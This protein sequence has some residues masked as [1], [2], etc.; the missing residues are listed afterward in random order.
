MSSSDFK[1]ILNFSKNFHA[2]DPKAL[3]IA[4]SGKEKFTELSLPLLQMGIRPQVRWAFD[5]FPFQS[6]VEDTKTYLGNNL[7]K[8]Q[9][10]AQGFVSMPHDAQIFALQQLGLTLADVAAGKVLVI[11]EDSGA[12]LHAKD[13]AAEEEFAQLSDYLKSLLNPGKFPD[14]ETGPVIA[15][16]GGAENFFYS[17]GEIAKRRP[18]DRGLTQISLVM[19][20]SLN[21][22]DE[23][24][25]VGKKL[26]GS[27]ISEP[28]PRHG[29]LT[30]DNFMIPA[31]IDGT[32]ENHLTIAELGEA[33]MARH[34]VKALALQALVKKAGLATGL[35]APVVIAQRKADLRVGVV[36]NGDPAEKLR[37]IRAPRGVEIVPLSA[38]IETLAAV[39]TDIFA[40]AD[41][42]VLAFT[43]D[44]AAARENYWRNLYILTSLCT[45]LLT[46]DRML[47]GKGAVLANFDNRHAHLTDFAD[48]IHALGN[49]AQERATLFDVTE[50]IEQGLA[51]LAEKQGPV[52]P[53]Q[54]PAFVPHT[55]PGSIPPHSDEGVAVLLSGLN[56]HG[57]LMRQA[58]KFALHQ[59]RDEGRPIITGAG[60]R[61][62]MGG[63]TEILAP[64]LSP[65]RQIW[66]GGA[67]TPTIM[68]IEGN[69]A[70]QLSH[71]QLFASIY[72]RMRY[73]FQ[74]GLAAWLYGG[75]G[76]YQ[77]GS[78]WN[79]LQ[80]LNRRGVR[81]A[82]TEL[83][84]GKPMAIYN[85][86]IT[87][88]GVVRGVYDPVL[89]SMPEEDREILNI[90]V[91]NSCPDMN[92]LVNA[93][94]EERR[95]LGL[96]RRV[97]PSHLRLA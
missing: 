55:R 57:G 37:G 21:R 45:G 43:G 92:Q 27:W 4:T 50:S 95:T 39:E 31:T 68:G 34:S 2:D 86:Q 41:S 70:D 87:Q 35:S 72:P 3:L 11:T 44:K 6:P 8:M 65:E 46:H 54:V 36:V 17:L 48:D 40:R 93:A 24:V 61:G 81:N 52:I 56:E 25:C 97:Q 78:G 47:E 91:A 7:K 18:L 67:T 80:H 84:A 16:M 88:A 74:A 23:I 5:L 64:L 59:A 90:G 66:H 60:K 13:I 38:E 32:A 96:G 51:L 63:I 94:F 20:A 82:D 42:F 33:Y 26:E 22:P 19:L 28:R 77:E 83:V 14:V 49:A 53:K 79:M 10:A 76:T 75:W 69:V 85:H 73:I 9:A 15:A 62:G 29:P 71:F 12:R 89:M 58:Q 30:M 1:H